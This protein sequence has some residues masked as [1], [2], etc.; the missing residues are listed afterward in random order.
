[1]SGISDLN[2]NPLSNI[3]CGCPASVAAQEASGL[4]ATRLGSSSGHEHTA[5]AQAVHMNVCNEWHDCMCLPRN[6]PHSALRPM[7]HHPEVTLRVERLRRAD[8]IP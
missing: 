6:F 8:L 3:L 7:R 5:E 2:P 1:M 4:R